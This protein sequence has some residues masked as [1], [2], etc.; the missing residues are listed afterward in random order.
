[1]KVALTV[2]CILVVIGLDWT[3][4]RLTELFKSRAISDFIVYTVIITCCIVWTVSTF[5][6]DIKTLVGGLIGL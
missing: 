2:F 1:M 6:I 4:D 5:N 3:A